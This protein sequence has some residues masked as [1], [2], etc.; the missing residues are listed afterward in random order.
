[1]FLK[2]VTTTEVYGGGGSKKLKVQN[3]P[4]NL[5]HV[6]IENRKPDTS[7]SL[8][9]ACPCIVPDPFFSFCPQ[10]FPWESL[11]FFFFSSPPSCSFNLIYFSS[12]E[13][14]SCSHK[15]G[16]SLHWDRV[17]FVVCHY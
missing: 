15:A 10:R 17:R 16:K 13:S 6:L 3:K 14:Q 8:S 11:P 5:F 4:R 7:V 2:A 12:Y 1:M 9:L